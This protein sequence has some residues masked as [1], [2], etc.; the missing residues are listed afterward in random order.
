MRCI[1]LYVALLFGLFATSCVNQRVE[2][3][4]LKDCRGWS[5]DSVANGAI[6][7]SYLGYY[8]PM[9]ANQCVNVMEFDLSVEG[10]SMEF[11]F[12]NPG[13]S[14]STVAKREG[15]FA[16]VNGTY[17]PDGSYFKVDGEFFI[18]NELLE[19]DLRYWK[20]EGALFFNDS[21]SEMYISFCT[22][23]EYR[24]SEISNII[25]GSPMLI[26][27]FKPVGEEFVGDVDG[28][29]LNTLEYEDY[30]RHQGVRHPRTAV[31]ITA[32]DKLLLITVDGRQ[33]DFAA[34]MTAKE[35]TQ[36]INRYFAPKSALNI[37]GGGSTTMWMRGYPSDNEGVVNYPTDNRKFDHYGQRK[38]ITFILL[39]R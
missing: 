28:L 3:P 33:R 10:N 35:L 31:A 22:D 13:D 37:D 29:D 16:G 30:R 32:D 8:E 34:G 1:A 14:L 38:V 20:H 18:E 9:E 23:E 19:D 25:S 11:L 12:V 17:E 21:S 36:F 24:S 27:N 39:K 5:V 15:A 26:D 6:L 4:V 7:Y 2:E